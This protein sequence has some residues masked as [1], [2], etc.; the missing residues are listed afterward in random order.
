MGLELYIEDEL[1]DL[2]GDEQISTD[3]AIAEIGNFATR[4]GFRS[5]NFD[6]PKTANNNR[7]LSNSY[8]VNNSTPRPYRRLKARVFVDGID[9][10]IRFADIESVQDTY[11]MRL[12]GGNANFFDI[13]K[14][15]KI[16]ELQYLPSLNHEFNLTNVYDSRQN[17]DGYI[18]PLIDW[19]ADSPNSIMSNTSKTFNVQFC[20]PCLFVDEILENICTD[21]GYALNNS[22]LNDANY[23]SADLIFPISSSAPDAVSGDATFSGSNVSIFNQTFVPT[24]SDITINV[25]SFANENGLPLDSQTD[26]FTSDGFFAFAPLDPFTATLEYYE[27]PFSGNYEIT[28][29]IQGIKSSNAQIQAIIYKLNGTVLEEKAMSLFT[30]VQG[31]FDLTIT[32]NEE[33]TAGDLIGCIVVNI[34]NIGATPPVTIQTARFDIKSTDLEIKYGRVVLFENIQNKTKQSDFLK[35][36]LQMFSCLVTVD[37][38][39]KTVNINKFNELFENIPQARDWSDKIDYTEENNLEFSLDKYGQEN[40]LEYKA[41][42]SIDPTFIQGANGVITIDDNTLPFSAEIVKLPFAATEMDN[43]LEAFV[44]PKIKIFTTVSTRTPQTQ[45]TDKVE[46][47]ILLLERVTTVPSVIYSD[48]TTTVT[49]NV[50]L[51]L[52]WFMLGSKQLNLGFGNNL[53]PLYYGGLQSVLTRTKIVTEQLRLN[54]LDIQQLDFLRPVF[55]SK[56]NAY[57]YISKISGFTYGSSESTEVELVKLR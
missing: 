25:L 18:Y 49:T 35:A 2:I 14:E 10:N 26:T 51:P 15:R 48:G 27:I 42:A 34:E 33:L 32:Y 20:Y 57:F 8:L 11:N 45:P 22:L 50:D 40:S 16:N 28:F 17:N 36:Y 5:I 24:V 12:Y 56:H 54:A 52:A 46:Q 23:Q 19:H 3:Y 55:L 6:I 37:E 9:Q 29:N 38:D 47:R 21:A 44:I 41:D 53:I 43:R 7:I 1:I 13:I 30:T 4:S 39:T 31:T